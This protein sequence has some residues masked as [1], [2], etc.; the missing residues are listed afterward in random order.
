MESKGRRS[1][2][3][4]FDVEERDGEL[5][6]R[7]YRFR[8]L[9]LLLSLSLVGGIAALAQDP[10]PTEPGPV[11]PEPTEPEP[12]EPEPIDALEELLRTVETAEGVSDQSKRQLQDRLMRLSERMNQFGSG[13]DQEAAIVAELEA[14]RGDDA[15]LSLLIEAIL[16]SYEAGHKFDVIVSLLVDLE[17]DTEPD[18]P[19]LSRVAEIAL[20][21]ELS[22]EDNA[23]LR[24]ALQT[25]A[26]PSGELNRGQLVST[27]AHIR[28]LERKARRDGVDLTTEQLTELARAGLSDHL[29][30]DEIEAITEAALNSDRGMSEAVGHIRNAV[31]PNRKGHRDTPE[32][33]PSE[34]TEPPSE[35]EDPVPE[36]PDEAEEDDAVKVTMSSNG[37]G[38]SAAAASKGKNK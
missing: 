28:N 1:R 34:D 29:S 13:V 33:D 21:A 14:L 18:D 19:T 35:D 27:M 5:N 32:P 15:E 3:G 38:R 22:K 20:E 2:L 17:P 8:A 31:T 6:R 26:E 30:D 7:L 4:G 12:T 10:L 24:T 37:R 23:A 16:A 11:E 36:V 25:E 9:V